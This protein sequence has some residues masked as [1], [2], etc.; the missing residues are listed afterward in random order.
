MLK[1]SPMLT[2]S[3]KWTLNL[4]ITVMGFLTTLLGGAGT[5]VGGPVGTLVGTG[6]GQ[7]GDTLFSNHLAQSNEEAARAWQEKMYTQQRDDQQKFWYEQ[8]DYNSPANQV[9]RL[10]EAGINPQL[11]LGNIQTGQ[12]GS[13]PSASVPATQI[14]Q[15]QNFQELN[16]LLDFIVGSKYAGEA[17]QEQITS[18]KLD[19]KAKEIDLQTQLVK[20]L[21]SLQDIMAGISNKKSGAAKNYNDIEIANMMA[22]PQFQ[23]YMAEIGNI[24][25]NTDY[26]VYQTMRGWT[27]L[28]YLPIDKRVQ[29]MEAI[30]RIDLMRRQGRLTKQQLIHE[31]QRTNHEYYASKGQRWLNQF[32]K[33]VEADLLKAREA[34]ANIKTYKP[35]LDT[36][37]DFLDTGRDF[38]DVFFR[39]PRTRNII[40]K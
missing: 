9:A 19:N 6:L 27:E 35:W 30:E 37:R 34:E 15:R 18:L 2:V 3:T 4:N 23:K 28:Q 8:Q 12:M 33:K 20:N 24:M 13:L 38:L 1:C 5:L 29:Y 32:N 31:I 22:G 39:G 7:L 25:A 26:T 11:A 10:R 16:G 21:L 36:G 17:K 14:A 40:L